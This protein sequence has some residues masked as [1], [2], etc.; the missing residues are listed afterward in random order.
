MTYKMMSLSF[1]SQ[2]LSEKLH[3]HKYYQKSEIRNIFIRK[4]G[5]VQCYLL[6]QFS[7]VYFVKN[8]YTTILKTL[9]KYRG[10]HC[11]KS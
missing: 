3:V 4:K 2:S 6:V 9:E 7:S 5:K 10:E 11:Q 8:L 1:S